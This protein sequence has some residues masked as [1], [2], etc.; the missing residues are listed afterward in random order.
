MSSSIRGSGVL[1]RF[2]L[3]F[4]IQRN[5]DTSNLH[6]FFFAFY[7]SLP[8]PDSCT[9]IRFVSH[10]IQ[11]TVTDIAACWMRT[12]LRGPIFCAHSAL[13]GLHPYVSHDLDPSW[14]YS[15]KLL[16]FAVRPEEG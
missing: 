14:R 7:N 5:R 6:S 16:S 11:R 3:L 1:I 10:R 9:R 4:A 13:F 12:E 2:N 15:P 8:P